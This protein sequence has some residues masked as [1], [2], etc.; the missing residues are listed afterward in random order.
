MNNSYAR[1]IDFLALKQPS[2]GRFGHYD[3]LSSGKENISN[4]VLVFANEISYILWVW[5]SGEPTYVRAKWRG[6]IRLLSE[7]TGY[8]LCCLT[9]VRTR[10]MVF[11]TTL[12]IQLCA[13]LYA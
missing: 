4:E 9:S 2:E 11:C 3:G 5:V 13:R 8:Q 1:F 10:A 12:P 7:T 6:A